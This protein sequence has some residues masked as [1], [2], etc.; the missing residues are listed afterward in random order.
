MD[1]RPLSLRERQLEYLRVLKELDRFCQKKGLR[2]YLGCGTLIGAVRHKGFIPWDDDLDVFMPRPDFKKMIALYDS[3]TFLFHTI[4]NDK[5]HPYNFGRLCS[6]RVCSYVNNTQ[7]FNFGI[8]VYVI[9]GAP[10]EIEKRNKLFKDT[11]SHIKKKQKLAS[12]NNR[13]KRINFKIASHLVSNWLNK[14]LLSAERCFE[15]YDFDKCDYIWP[16]GGGRLIMKKENYGSPIKLEFEGYFFNAPEHY[17][18][19]LTLGY[20][21]YMQLPP[22]EKR[23]PYHTGT[24]F[25]QV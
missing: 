22:V 20:G 9:N 25:Y 2:Y 3:K 8:D 6:D 5:T 19:V 15:R 24:L 13:F 16:Y 10:T 4:Y 7:V 23:Y 11:F 21:D 12:L 17:H 1:K 18:E 14:E